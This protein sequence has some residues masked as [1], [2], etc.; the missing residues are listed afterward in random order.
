MFFEKKQTLEI[1]LDI[2]NF[3][4]LL[5]K[6]WGQAQHFVSLNPLTVATTAQGGVVGPQGQA[7]YTMKVVNGALMDHTFEKNANLGDVYSFQL[8]VKYFF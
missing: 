2:L 4:N 5:N 6:N 3:T 8:G 1:R 7:Q